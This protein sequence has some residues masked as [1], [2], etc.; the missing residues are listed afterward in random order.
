MV[1]VVQCEADRPEFYRKLGEA[2]QCPPW[3]VPT[4]LSIP[5]CWGI[6]CSALPPRSHEEA[7]AIADERRRKRGLPPLPEAVPGKQTVIHE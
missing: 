5:Q 2:Y 7:V 4:T 6:W 3:I 1:A